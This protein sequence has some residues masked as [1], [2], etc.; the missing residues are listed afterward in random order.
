M[1]KLK[2]IGKQVKEKMNEINIHTISDLHKHVQPYKLPKLPIQGFGR[3][4][5]HGLENLPGKPTPPI[6]DHRKSKNP[7]YR[8][9]ER[10]G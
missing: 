7:Y 5:E 6:K 4:Y 10:Y 9:M 3:F 1:G 8:D 2:G